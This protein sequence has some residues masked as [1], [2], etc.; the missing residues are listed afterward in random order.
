[1]VEKVEMEEFVWK[2]LLHVG[3]G[4]GKGLATLGECG[5]EAL[6]DRGGEGGRKRP[7]LAKPGPSKASLL[8][9]L[10]KY[11]IEYTGIKVKQ[12][13][14]TLLQ[15]MSNVKKSVAERTRHKRLYDRRVNKRRMQ[16]QE[17]KVDLGKTLD[18][19][20]VVMESSETE[21]GK[22]DTSSRS[23]NDAEADNAD[24]KPVYD[25]EP[26]AKVQLTAEC[27]IFAT[28]QQHTEQPELNNE[29]GVDQYTERCQV[30][31]LM[32]DS[33]IYNKTTEFSNQSLESENICLKK[34]VAQFQK[35]FSRMGAHCIAFELKYQNQALKSRQQGQILNEASNKAK[36]KKEI[37]AFETINNELEH[38][39]AKL[40]AENEHLHKENEHLK[41]TY[42]D[43]YDSIK[44]TRVQTKDH[45]DSLIVQLNNKST[46]NA[47]L[48]AQIQEK[49]FAIAALKNELRK[50]KG[51]SVDT[52]FT[53][54]SI[55]GKPVLQSL[56]NQ[57]V[58]RQ[59]NAFKSERPKISKPRFS[60]Q[61]DVKNDFSN[62]VTQHYLPKGREFAFA[63]LIT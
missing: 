3:E 40:L 18:A 28:G 42:K 17:S 11:F 24:I 4:G 61:V 26:M 47:D 7:T 44:K 16:K 49:V 37:D 41:Q 39:V 20:L 53:K 57:S 22:Q 62:P 9:P 14:E 51:N 27:N 60:S 12:I 1:M 46:K 38:S 8:T 21:S 15:H 54:P 19:G 25:E 10:D 30:K 48:K 50:L 52:K 36:R 32:L 31:S 63:K 2:H 56:R 45:N 59:P 58:V 13:K 29:G 35:D 5:G 55:L 43:L 23:G 34:T 6:C 33:L